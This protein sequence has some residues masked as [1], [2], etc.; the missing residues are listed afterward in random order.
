[1]P[2]KT[3]CCQVGY[4]YSMHGRTT[5]CASITKYI[6]LALSTNTGCWPERKVWPHVLGPKAQSSIL[7]DCAGH[8]GAYLLKHWVQQQCLLSV[9]IRDDVG[10]RAGCCIEQLPERKVSRGACTGWTAG[11]NTA[12]TFKLRLLHECRGAVRGAV[13]I[14]MDLTLHACPLGQG[15]V[16]G[17]S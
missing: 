10:V 5:P 1:M 8:C 15:L 17:T 12:G 14:K 16:L 4:Q 2:A 7:Q 11:G 3:L 13:E 9:R 6:F